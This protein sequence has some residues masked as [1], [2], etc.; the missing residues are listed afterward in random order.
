LIQLFGVKQHNHISRISPLQA[1]C[2]QG[3][4][5]FQACAGK[6]VEVSFDGG[7]LSS[8]GGAVLLREQA[9]ALRLGERLAGCFEDRRDPRYVEHRVE[10][11][12]MQR[13]VGLALGYED[14][15]D[16]QKLRH[17]AVVSLAAGKEA[18]KECGSAA[19]LNRVELSAHR[20]GKYH[21]VHVDAGRMEEE[22]LKIG[23]GSLRRN[24]RT[25]I[26]DFDAT[27]DPLHGRQE[28]RFF[29]GY[30][31]NYCYLPLYAFVGETI[32][33]AQLRTADRDAASGTVEALEKIVPVLRRRCPRARIVVRADSG[34]C[35]EAILEWCERNGV[36]YVIGLARNERLVRQLSPQMADARIRATHCGRARVFGEFSYRTRASWSR[37]RR[38]LG[39]AERLA[40][41]D[42][43]RFVVTSLPGD[44]QWLYEQ[45]YCERGNMENR[46]KEQQLELF[47]DRLSSHK[48]AANQLRLWLSAFAYVLVERLRSHALKGT[49]LARAT[50]GT[51]RCQ[52]FKLAARI[53]SSTRRIRIRLCSQSPFKDV[54]AHAWAKLRVMRV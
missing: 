6:K 47:A 38:V 45:V 46:I 14:L 3:K 37:P 42:N 17:D 49:R 32:L 28:G 13:V 7:R 33:W 31:G 9:L 5:E 12:L 16:H 2:E 52:L 18:G 44:P 40:D 48:M 39:K 22:L 35:R 27:D 24:R 29:H 30:Y 36:H 4:F 23:A 51:I 19:T 54:F 20:H 41:K 11:L 8:D 26:I 43:P 50:V 1:E 21:K 25:L 15:N 34:F 53:E 10:E